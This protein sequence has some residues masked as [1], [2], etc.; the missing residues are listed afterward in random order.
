[1][2]I[3]AAKRFDRQRNL[4]YGASLV[5]VDSKVAHVLSRCFTFFRKLF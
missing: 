3:D 4:G 5:F 2:Q 1:M